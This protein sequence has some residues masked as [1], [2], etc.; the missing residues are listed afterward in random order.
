MPLTGKLLGLKM[1]QQFFC[2]NTTQRNPRGQEPETVSLFRNYSYI[3]FR[4]L[5]E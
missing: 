3:C 1:F 4:S 2:A 5:G